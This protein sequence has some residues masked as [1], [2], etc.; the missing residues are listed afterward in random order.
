LGFLEYIRELAASNKGS[1]V[2]Y[3]PAVQNAVQVMTVHK[4]KG[5]EFPVVYVPHLAK[6][7]FP[8]RN[9]GRGK[10]P[11][12]PGLAHHSELED[13]EEEDRC[14]F[15]VALTRA[16]D[17]LVLSRAE[18]YGRRAGAL[19]LIDRL[20]R[21]A[22]GRVM[23]EEKRWEEAPDGLGGSA[24]EEA[25]ESNGGGSRTAY[26]FRELERY[27]KCSLQYRYAEIVG[28]PEKRS[29]YQ[30]FHNSVY[31]VLSEMELE[32]KSRG[33]NPDLYWLREL[34]ARVWEEE[35][36]VGHFYEPV[37]RR[38]AEM[39]V[40]YWQATEAALRWQVRE[41]LSLSA[42]EET[43]IEV[44]ADAVRRDDDGN[45]IVARHRFGRPRKSHKEGTHNQ[46]RHALYMAA[47]EDTWPEIPARVELHYLTSGEVVEATP[48][49]TITRNR[50]AK[51]RGHV[52]KAS[53]GSFPANPGQECKSCPWNL[54]CPSSA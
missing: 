48:T 1:G 52:Q 17:E 43:R 10:V 51:F 41:K 50:T 36:P 5:L 2:L 31:R 16:E 38:H 30:A 29:A 53:S 14:L 46:D 49:P 4:S 24:A 34:L 19:A 39:A 11:L 44:I 26:S 25:P 35:G 3:A 9:P 13:R 12:P 6:G 20:V 18:A 21:E 54:V 33:Q 27:G 32:A 23:V 45:I 15:Y 37:Y 28:L 22:G 7:H 42:P 40:K 47:A 8:V